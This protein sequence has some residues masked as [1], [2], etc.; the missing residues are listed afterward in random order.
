MMKYIFFV[1]VFCFL[2][3]SPVYRA[4]AQAASTQTTQTFDT[5][6]FPQWAK[7]LRR[8]NIIAF[9]S[10]PLTMFHTTFYTDLH[11]WR[12]A[13]E[14]D[15]SE[16][17]RRYAPWP[18]KSAGAVAMTKEEQER[19]ILIAAGL[20]VAVALT[21]FIIV[22]IKRNRE[23]RHTESRPA[24]SAIINVV[25]FGIPEDENVSLDDPD[26]NLPPENDDESV[27]E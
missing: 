6:G 24:S 27:F 14:L 26:S 12:E 8:M 22:S 23:R 5:T 19:T 3:L 2:L 17:G 18:L 20:S 9:G 4:E 13:N 16:E 21:D 7:D 11:R 1:I 15:F 25:P 10:F